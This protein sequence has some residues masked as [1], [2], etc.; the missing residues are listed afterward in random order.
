MVCLSTLLVVIAG[1]EWVQ[2]AHGPLAH[3]HAERT[4]R[5][6]LEAQ[7]EQQACLNPE[8]PVYCS[9]MAAERMHLT[10]PCLCMPCLRQAMAVW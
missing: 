9:Y 10:G 2:A 8:C 4:E 3:F 1:E 5:L 7:P 6:Q